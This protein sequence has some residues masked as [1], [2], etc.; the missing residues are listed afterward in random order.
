MPVT[1]KGLEKCA[2]KLEKH[3]REAQDIEFTV[4]RGKLYLLQTRG[5]KM[6]PRER[7]RPPSTW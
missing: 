2:L 4:E 5:A 7:S 1:Y 3:F 6:G